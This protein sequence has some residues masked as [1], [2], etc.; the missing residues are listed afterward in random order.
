MEAKLQGVYESIKM[1]VS[2]MQQG[3]QDIISTFEN[4]LL[5]SNRP[6]IHV[7]EDILRF[8]LNHITHVCF[9]KVHRVTIKTTTIHHKGQKRSPTNEVPRGD[10]WTVFYDKK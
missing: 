4:T 6:D 3:T 7:R 9:E 5:E 10:T 1:S 8:M 2:H